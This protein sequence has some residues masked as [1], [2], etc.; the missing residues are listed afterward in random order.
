MPGRENRLRET[1]I[2]SLPELASVIADA[3]TS[4]GDLPFAFFGHS[5]GAIVAFETARQLRRSQAQTPS[6]LF[7]SASRAPQLPWPHSPVRHLDNLELL[8]EV[9]R[10][11]ESV[12]DVIMEDAELRELLTPALR[13][14]MALVETYV[15]QPE[16]PFECP[17]LA[18]GGDDDRMV[19][20][21]ELE[22]WEVHT[23]ASFRLRMLSGD[24]L[25]LQSRRK[26]LLTDIASAMGI[27]SDSLT[28]VAS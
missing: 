19:G 13:A 23:S 3:V 10:R 6:T 25:F 22:Q 12:P 17:V 9:H 27:A 18:F 28:S 24:H 1:P 14:D 21:P 16:D 15:H 2:D 4:S 8:R 26:E 7:V 5:L 20:R 11:Y